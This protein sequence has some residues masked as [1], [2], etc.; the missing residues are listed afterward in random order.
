MSGYEYNG[1]SCQYKSVDYSAS[2]YSAYSS[3]NSSCPLNSHTSSSDSS[4]CQCDS[5]YDV[6]SNKTA[7]VVTAPSNTSN[8]LTCP[9]GYMCTVDSNAQQSGNCPAGYR[10][11]AV[12][13][14]VTV[15][16]PQDTMSNLITKNLKVG[17]SGEDVGQ[18]QGYLE[19]QGFLVLPAGTY[20]GYY[21]SLTKEAVKKF[22]K[23]NSLPTTGEFLIS[24][25]PLL[26]KQ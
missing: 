26:N 6:N 14:R 23:N 19:E 16:P 4:K 11:T 10:C 1:S 5:G 24:M 20:P 8:V 15:N 2:A 21:G 17:D 22:Q 13:G 18:L 9:I 3:T 12:Q 25:K 7:C